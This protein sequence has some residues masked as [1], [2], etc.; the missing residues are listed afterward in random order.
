MTGFETDHR[1]TQTVLDLQPNCEIRPRLNWKRADTNHVRAA[2]R[3]ALK[4][5]NL[6][7]PLMT[8]A[9]IDEFASTF[10]TLCYAAI[11]AT[12]P[13]S[14]LRSPSPDLL[15]I[16][17][18]KR[19]FDKARSFRVTGSL[20][21][22]S[23]QKHYQ[24]LLWKAEKSLKQAKNKSWR[25]FI[26]SESKDSRS[27]FRTS[28]LGEH[29]CRPLG[30]PYLK[31]FVVDK[32]VYDT[33]PAMLDIY[34]NHLWCSHTHDTDA[35]LIPEPETDP[36]REQLPCPQQLKEGEV[37][38]LIDML[39][40]PKAGGIDGVT[41]KFLKLAQDI[42]VPYLEHLFSAC[43]RLGHEP[44]CFKQAKTIILRKPGKPSH[45]PGS[46]RPIALLSSVGKLLERIVAHRLRDL[47]LEYNIL[48][49]TQFGI[50]GRCTTKALQKLLDSVYIAWSQNRFA[51]LM[52]LDIAGAFNRVDR[53]K[54]LE[55]LRAKRIPGKYFKS[56]GFPLPQTL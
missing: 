51:T 32:V 27:L 52:S 36:R 11:T 42:I 7:T 1:V 39:K 44:S 43:I 56:S 48:P 4:S 24:N 55:T 12:V 9:E 31:S 6:A 37:R 49:K 33:T 26:S 8:V 54:L 50:A 18:V 22:K 40:D 41:N 5:L 46:W 30:I 21:S 34:K 3:G 14:Q 23:G 45:L 16:P 29:M 38:K 13:Q 20:H 35:T 17:E 47:N 28:R 10:I 19:A 15:M 2:I 25:K 53:N